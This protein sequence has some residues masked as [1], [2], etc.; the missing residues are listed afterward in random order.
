MNILGSERMVGT[1]FMA[2]AL[3]LLRSVWK[4][5]LWA[6]VAQ[7]TP[8]MGGCKDGEKDRPVALLPCCSCLTA[9]QVDGG[10]GLG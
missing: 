5:P 3:L 6:H 4:S 8:G 10:S 9:T 1:Q 2:L 7:G